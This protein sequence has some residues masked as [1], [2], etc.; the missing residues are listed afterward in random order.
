[1]CGRYVFTSN[2]EAVRRLFR[3]EGSPNLQPRY[4]IAPTQQITLIRVADHHREIASA[5]WGLLP[6]WAKDMPKG[7][8]VINAKA[9]TIAEKPMFRA[10]LAKRRCLVPADG[11][12]E[13]QATADG[14]QP[15][16]IGLKS[17]E[18]FAFAGIWERW[19]SPGGEAIDSAA[20]I[21]TEPNELM[22]PIHDRMPAILT[23]SAGDAWLA[24]EAPRHLA[25]LLAPY[26]AGK[27]RAYRVATSVNSP[28]HDGPDLIA[29]I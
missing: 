14:K 19:I 15:F 18:P 28:K 5:R 26:D 4:N 11:F 8:P 27:M 7:P 22:A 21:T 3:F 10:A 29:P 1:M 2:V 24:D 25:T 6:A 13:W 12:Y 23:G 20:I 17:G 16:L 9:E